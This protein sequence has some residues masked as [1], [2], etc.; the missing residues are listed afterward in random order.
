MKMKTAACTVAL[1][2][3]SG[4][5]AMGAVIATSD[6]LDFVVGSGS[7]LS[8]L[9]IDFN[10]GAAQE[11]F[12]W[13]YRWDGSATGQ[14]LLEAIEGADS[15]LSFNST[16]FV[17]EV[18]YF[19]GTTSHSGVSDFGAGALSF[20]Y[21]LAGGSADTFDN[22]D[23]SFTGTIPISGGGV[24]LPSSFLISPSGTAGRALENGSW[25]ALSFGAFNPETFD[26]LVPPGPEAPQ[27]AAIPEPS[28]TGLL[29]S[30]LLICGL[31]RKR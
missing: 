28:V 17:T 16:S 14:D 25:D 22:E 8:V 23:F 4:S 20:G 26:H 18:N 5:L 21:Y 13:G 29:A 6:D 19:D 7:N 27:A 15:N 31:R 1:V 11:S 24:T 12:A 30:L 10:D 9:V 3:A 2:M